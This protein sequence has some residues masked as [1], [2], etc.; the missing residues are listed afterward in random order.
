MIIIINNSA[1]TVHKVTIL[2]SSNLHYMSV[3]CPSPAGYQSDPPK[4]RLS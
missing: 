4:V 1:Q 2:Y 3:C